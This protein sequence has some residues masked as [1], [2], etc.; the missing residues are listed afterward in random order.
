M[1]I[2]ALDSSTRLGSVALVRDGAPVAEY[3]LSVQ[4]TH[5]ER[6]LPAV[7]QVLEDAGVT[8]RD[9]E[10][11]AVTRGPGSFTGLRIALATAKG[12]AYAL[13]RPIVGVGTLDALAFGVAGWAEFVC[14]LLDA[15]RGQAYAAVFRRLPDGRLARVTDYLALPVPAILDRLA[16]AAGAGRVAFVGDAVPLHAALLR[17][18]WGERAVFP[19]EAV[20]ALRAAWVA[21]LAADRLARGESDSAETLVPLY[22]RPPEAEVRWA[23][24]QGKEGEERCS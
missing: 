23:E 15:R 1:L 5:A 21:A 7:A 12:L 8:P 3:T 9:L 10:A 16:Q 2:L 17:E 11:L 22:V 6:L 13:S 4:R 24:R 20:A 18:R 19:G 14:P